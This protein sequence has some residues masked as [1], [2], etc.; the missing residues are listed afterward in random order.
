MTKD[1][2]QMVYLAKR[3]QEASGPD[4][5]LDGDIAAYLKLFPNGWMRMVPD[6]HK[7]AD[8]L[9]E[10]WRWFRKGEW[11]DGAETDWYAPKLTSSLEAVI[12]LIQQ[13]LPGWGWKVGTCHVSDDAWVCPDFNDPEHAE[14]LMKEFGP[15]QFGSPYDHGFDVDRRPPGNLPL[16]LLE[17]LLMALISNADLRDTRRIEA[18][19]VG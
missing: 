18:G 13:L 4:R 10:P 19:K 1:E 17:A 15:P 9:N 5:R 8:G 12:A 2:W 11:G 6:E 3:V 14:R 16:A 7:H